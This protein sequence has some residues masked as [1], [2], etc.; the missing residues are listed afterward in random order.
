MTSN[1]SHSLRFDERSEEADRHLS[2]TSALGWDELLNG[3]TSARRGAFYHKSLFFPPMT[4]LDHREKIPFWRQKVKSRRWCLS[5]ISG[6]E[7]F[8]PGATELKEVNVRN[9]FYFPWYCLHISVSRDQ[10]VCKCTKKSY[11]WRKKVNAVP[12]VFLVNPK[13]DSLSKVF[14][15]KRDSNFK[16]ENTYLKT[17]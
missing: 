3:E 1:S 15:A 10:S 11:T 2:E 8:I 5:Y 17:Q 12:W 7:R 6:N 13:Y 9:D 14:L 4:D 16:F